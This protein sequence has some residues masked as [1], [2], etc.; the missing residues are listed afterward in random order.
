M[1]VDPD[2]ASSLSPPDAAPCDADPGA[3]SRRGLLMRV[4]F[5]SLSDRTIVVL[6]R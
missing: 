6:Q 1:D 3:I 5:I 4:G 2:L